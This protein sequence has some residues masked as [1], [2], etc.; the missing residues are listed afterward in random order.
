[1]KKISI[2]APVYN[3]EKVIKKFC[4]EVRSSVVSLLGYETE[5]IL[6]I[7]RSSDS[8]LEVIREL[9]TEDKTLKV[10][11]MSSRFGHQAALLAG[12]D[13]CESDIAIMMDSDL[14]H[15][16][17]LIPELVKKYEDGYDIV[18]TEKID[19]KTMPLKSRITSALY[20][21]FINI[22]AESRIHP[23]AADFRLITRKVIEIFKNDLR[24]NDLFI[25]G[26][27]SWVGFKQ[28]C[29]P[30]KVD[31]REFG[32]SKFSFNRLVSFALSGL[33]S[34]SLKPLRI[35]TY[36]GLITTVFAGI[37]ISYSL[38]S[39]FFAQVDLKG[40]TSLV[41]LICFFSGIQLTV[42]GILGE[43]IGAI[44]VESKKRPQYI[45]DE[46]INF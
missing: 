2:I 31:R 21:K 32:E 24:E 13:H 4:T 3:E 7:D 8:S 12:L 17:R 39:Y 15:P 40:W 26:L 10:I 16:P 22:F 45:I 23:Q 18:Y 20:Y 19:N 11:Y 37:F 5:I 42:M 41:I 35:A 1:M 43:Y 9:A 30:F 44:F 28:V 14:Q 33:L 27:I 34:F 46:K 6:C 36:I 29:V 38:Y 25:R